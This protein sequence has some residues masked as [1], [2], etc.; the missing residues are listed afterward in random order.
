MICKALKLCD[1]TCHLFPNPAEGQ[2][3]AVARV[4]RQ[5]A[6][7]GDTLPPLGSL[8]AICKLPGIKEICD[9]INNFA[10]NHN[11]LDDFDGDGF[12]CVHVRRYYEC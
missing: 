8:P 2:A 1:G 4:T 12:R 11:P 5:I 10:G 7:A 6:A 9:I 3:V